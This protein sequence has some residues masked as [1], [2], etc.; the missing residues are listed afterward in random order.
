MKNPKT[1]SL[2]LRNTLVA[3]SVPLRTLATDVNNCILTPTDGIM[4]EDASSAYSYIVA[5]KGNVPK[6]EDGIR[7]LMPGDEIRK[8]VCRIIFHIPLAN[9]CRREG[10]NLET[11]PLNSAAQ[12]KP[13]ILIESKDVSFKPLKVKTPA[14]SCNN[15]PQVPVYTLETYDNPDD[16]AFDGYIGNAASV[17]T[18]NKYIDG[19]LMRGDSLRPLLLRGQS[20][21]GKTELAKR[22]ARKCGKRCF[23]VAGSVLKKA[24]DVYALIALMNDG[25]VLFI[26]EAQ[27]MSDKSKAAIYDLTSDA[28]SKE[29]LIIFATN[30]SAKLPDALKNRC[31]EIRLT[32]Y[33]IAELAQMVNLTANECEMSVES[34]V[35]EYIAKRCHGVAR[36]AVN[37]TKDIITE[38]AGSGEAI[39]MSQAK[40][41]FDRRGIDE[42]GLKD[43]HR[44]YIKQLAMVKQASAA[45]LA[46][47]LGE[48]DTSEI[49]C[50]TEPLLLKH[51][52]ITITSKGRTLTEAGDKYA[53]TIIAKEV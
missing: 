17:L 37:Y 40:E 20:G 30:I 26:D 49:E 23:R 48:N 7:M 50:G 21:C 3:D 47:A 32:D 22:I 46:S 24:D 29:I 2:C 6:N 45:S 28:N 8:E 51:G 27:D 44:Q 35:A 19:A 31:L 36:Y 42:Y 53:Q 33:S 5:N 10:R 1:T 9:L 39:S 34:G 52:F 4:V 12:S 18:I 43:E 11:D 25:D 16:H 38:N 41:F 13:K 14:Q 15:Q